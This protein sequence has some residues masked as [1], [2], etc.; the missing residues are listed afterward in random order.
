[1]L[2]LFSLLSLTAWG[3]FDISNIRSISNTNLSGTTRSPNRT[4]LPD[5]TASDTA[6]ENGPKGVEYH[7]DIP[8][9][10][11]QASV[12]IVHRPQHQ[13]KIMKIEHPSLSPTGIQFS[14]CLDAL[15]E[16]YY[17]SVTEL[18][19]PHL[20]VAPAF[21]STPGLIYKSNVFPAFYK[22]PDNI[23]FY[24][25]QNP[26][27]LLSYNSSLDQDY[28]VHVTHSQNINDHWNFALDYHL[29]SPE[30]VFS[31]SSA[32][33]HLFDFNTNYYSP[34]ARY[35]ISAGF[36]WQRMVLGENG[37][38]SNED[39]Y[40]NKRISNMG[41]IPVKNTGRLSNNNDHTVFVRQ[42]YNTVRQFEWYR[43][44]KESFIDTVAVYDSV[45]YNIY[46]TIAHDTV[47]RDS[48]KISYRYDLRDTIVGYDTLQPHD[49]HV[50][51]TGVFGLE[52][53]WDN[54][55]YRCVDST[56]YN[57]LS[58][59][60]FWT[61]DAYMD[62]RWRNPLKIY[63]G[64]R[65]QLAW[66]VLDESL[67]T[68]ATVRRTALYPFGRVEFSPWAATV[69]N[70][71]AEAAPNLSEYNLDARLVFP[72][73]DSVGNSLRNLTFRASVKSL[74]PELIYTAQCL[75]KDSPVANNLKAIGLR[76]VEA[77][78]MHGNLL[79]VQLTAQHIS[80]NVWFKQY[81]LDESNTAL[82]PQ[83]SEGSALLLQ[84]RINLNLTVFS[85]LHY[86]MQQHLQYCND[87]EQIR[88]PLFASKNSIYADFKLFNNV[89]H[90][91][92]GTDI[93]FHTAYKADSYDPVLGTFY[94]QDEVE[95]GNYL[96][97]DFFINL[98]VK[99]AS[100]YAKAAHINSFLEEHS[101]CILPHYPA[102]QFGFFFGMTW[103]FFD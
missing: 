78:Y 54:Q 66:L 35:Q 5:S 41:G 98:Q 51:N 62:H 63:G 17:L 61:N 7:V 100:I 50:Y 8:D 90:T 49:P 3:Q 87:Q 40:L 48:V 21:E 77:E 75:R 57:R 84:G 103:K 64:I 81:S 26:Y 25:V 12:F 44:I 96:W 1:M 29:F 92:V 34:D 52:L 46:D 37:G 65:P 95:V 86:D 42:S 85:W 19:H 43:P 11:L 20:V 58:A 70:V 36:I 2:T 14:D 93:R 79:Q 71:Y 83:Q 68:S 18:G 32:T 69:L 82:F 89:L 72:F 101:Y 74:Q 67:Y 76:K 27:S 102:K 97:A 55:K 94:R 91:Q 39:S 9:S 15:N 16:N 4:N 31:N 53:Q 45:K 24:Q 22:T 30:G 6:S 23:N 28:Q 47:E 59:S 88:V 56:L 73:R 10:V 13:V 38:L 33:D 60:L 99:R 80:H